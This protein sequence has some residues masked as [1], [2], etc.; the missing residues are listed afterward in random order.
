MKILIIGHAQHG[1]DTAALELEEL[2]DFKFKSSS[3]AASEIFL[4]DALKYKY[5]YNTPMECFED[6]INH[7]KEWHDL[8]YLYN[9][10]DK[11]RLA[12]DILAQNDMYVGMRSNAEV[13]ECM[14]QRLFDWIIGIYDPRK[15]LEDKS[16][17]D[18]NIWEKA[19]IVI[20]NAHDIPSLRNKLRN[21]NSLFNGKDNTRR[22]NRLNA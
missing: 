8:I 6:R 9:Q 14:K 12:K 3:V 21:I 19:D 20:P 13:E 15:P 10:D 16:S 5:G 22:D 18:I 4:Y 7:R 11:A 17:F 2:Y 1:K